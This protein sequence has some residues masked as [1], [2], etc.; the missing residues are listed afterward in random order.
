MKDAWFRAV[1]GTRFD[2]VRWV[3][4]IGSTN[5]ELLQLAREG[6]PEGGVL[7]A[8]LQ[9]A[10]RGRRGRQ[11]TAPPGTS[12]M[13][14]VLLRPPAGVLAARKA[15][16]VTSVFAA[17]AAQAC[18][19]LVGVEP[20][21]KWPND[22]VVEI[23]PALRVAGDVGYRKLAGI[24]T[25]TVV[26]DSRIV[27]LV[28]GM[29]LNTGWAEV[30]DELSAVATSLNLLAGT[31]VDR[32]EL[33]RLI[34]GGFETRYASLVSGEGVDSASA[35]ARERSVTLGRQVRIQLAGDQVLEGMAKDLDDDGHLLVDD[36]AGVEHVVAVGDVVHL[37]PGGI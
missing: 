33:A 23:D 26:A 37:R 4:E 31:A 5:T 17:A 3:P 10:G 12:L 9:T 29:G 8:D 19:E 16:W 11:W 27:A 14:S 21:I 28:V 30:P 34:L 13:M 24:L 1:Q 2:R 20:G 15:S 18:G 36:A 35:E 6:A 25:E 7:I 22:L 32:P